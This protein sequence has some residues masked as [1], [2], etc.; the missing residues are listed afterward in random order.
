MSD[1]NSNPQRLSTPPSSPRQAV[2]TVAVSDDLEHL[3]PEWTDP[4]PTG[5]ITLPTPES[6]TPSDIQEYRDVLPTLN[7]S[8]PNEDELYNHIVQ[9]LESYASLRELP[10]S[11]PDSE[12]L[13]ELRLVAQNECARS[14]LDRAVRNLYR[15]L[16][17]EL[18]QPLSSVYFPHLTYFPALPMAT[19]TNPKISDNTYKISP[20]KGRDNFGIWKIQMIDMYRETKLYNIIAGTETLPVVHTA[21][22]GA[23]TPKGTVQTAAIDAV[24]QD[25]V[26]SW[27]DRNQQALGLLRRRVETGP[28]IHVAMST[29][30]HLAWV[31]LQRVYESVGPAAMTNLCG[32]FYNIR[33]A[34]SDDL[35][36]HIGCMRKALDALNTALITEGSHPTIE[37]EFI[38][39]LLMTLPESYHVLRSTFNQRPEANDPEGV[40]LSEELQER[41]LAEYQSCKI[42]NGET[43][44]YIRNR[45]APGQRNNKAT[46]NRQSG[47]GQSSNQRAIDRTRITCNHC[48]KVGHIKAECFAPGGPKDRTKNNRQ[49][50]QRNRN[51][52]TNNRNKP[53][54]RNRNNNGNNKQTQEAHIVNASTSQTGLNNNEH[55][56][57]FTLPSQYDLEQICYKQENLVS[58]IDSNSDQELHDT[59]MLHIPNPEPLAEMK[60]TREYIPPPLEK[61]LPCVKAYVA[62]NCKDLVINGSH[63]ST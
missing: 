15:E 56:F 8:D 47:N 62:R 11:S 20:L 34:E 58:A 55:A 37:L 31:A 5:R 32:N 30:A 51:E 33:M 13:E 36:E 22:P 61:D 9:T 44:Y 57:S 40:V 60:Q 39:Q 49:G 19:P 54:Q 41:L 17:F 3:E 27:N 45:F 50:Q 24:T 28:M 25:H 10:R 18:P 48:G 21:I 38:R 43:G 63:C 16:P 53:N 14:I 52:N 1:S 2:S 7:R 46:P 12:L 42:Q 26:N 29:E 6:H 35:E 4:E 59:W 23:S